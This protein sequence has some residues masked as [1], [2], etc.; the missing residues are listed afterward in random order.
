[1]NKYLFIEVDTQNDFVKPDGALYVPGSEELIPKWQR[2]RDCFVKELR[3]DQKCEDCKVKG[4]YLTFDSHTPDDYE[5]KKYGFAP[6]CV[7]GTLGYQSWSFGANK[8]LLFWPSAQRFRKNTFDIWTNHSFTDSIYW[9]LREPTT[10]IIFGV[11]TDYCVADCVDGFLLRYPEQEL[12]LVTDAV[13]G[14]NEENVEKKM[15]EWKEKGVR[16][17]TV[18]DV[19]NILNG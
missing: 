7:N 9:E 19:E 15:K 11:A 14:I 18:D 2:L 8:D 10:T 13:K 17:V 3:K 5:F 6:H 1:M 4:Y 12:V 16:M